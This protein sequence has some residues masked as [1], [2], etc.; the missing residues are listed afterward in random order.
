MKSGCAA[1]AATMRRSERKSGLTMENTVCTEDGW[2]EGK[3][4]A[5]GLV[6]IFDRIIDSRMMGKWIGGLEKTTNHKII[7]KFLLFGRFVAFSEG[8]G[9]TC[10]STL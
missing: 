9:F 7:H 10:H 1:C 6:W 4:G 8:C 5:G 3:N 2:R